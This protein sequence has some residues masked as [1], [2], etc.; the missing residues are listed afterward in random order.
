MDAALR[1][2][3]RIVISVALSVAPKAV[4]RAYAD[5]YAETHEAA[6]RQLSQTAADAVLQS[7]EVE[8]KPEALGPG[9][10]SRFMAPRDK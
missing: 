10:H 6:K 3:L 8:R 2:Y 5:R 7:F 4:K 9:P 1:E